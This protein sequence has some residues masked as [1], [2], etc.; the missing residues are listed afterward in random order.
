MSTHALSNVNPCDLCIVFAQATFRG[1]CCLSCEEPY[2]SYS[3][4]SD[5]MGTYL[6]IP[7]RELAPVYLL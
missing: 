6:S 1:N 5:I 3:L 2:K 7:E 4:V